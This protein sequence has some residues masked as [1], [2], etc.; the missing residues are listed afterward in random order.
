MF[1]NHNQF[2]N[3]RRIGLVGVFILGILSILGSGGGGGGGDQVT[4]IIPPTVTSTIPVNGAMDVSVNIVVT[5]TFSEDMDDSTIDTSSFTL[6]SNPVTQGT[7]NYDPS[8]RTV[9]FTP[10]AYLDV[11]TLYTAVIS[12]DVA[13]LAGNQMVDNHTWNFTAEPA[14]TFCASTSDELRTALITAA[15]NGKDDLIHV[16]QGIYLGN[17]VYNSTEAFSLTVYGG[18]SAGCVSREIDPA[19]TILDALGDGLVLGLNTDKV[20]DFVVDGLTMRNASTIVAGAGVSVYTGGDLTLSN[21]LISS[22]NNNTSTSG[23]GGGVHVS[24]RSVTFSDNIISDNTAKN[25]GGGAWISANIVALT[26]NTISNNTSRWS[27][28]VAVSNA[29]MVTL[30]NNTVSGNS[31]VQFG[32]AVDIVA[33]TVTLTDN[34]IRNNTGDPGGLK[35]GNPASGGSDV[36]LTNNNF[37]GNTSLG[38]GGG[39]EINAVTATLMNNAISGNTASRGAGGGFLRASTA[40]LTNNVIS[41]NISTSTSAGG[42]FVS[43]MPS[44]GTLKLTNNTITSNVAATLGGGVQ[45]DL[46][47]D[48]VIADM[49]NNIVWG[50]SAPQGADLF[51]DNDANGNFVPSLANLFNNDFDQSSGGIFIT[52]PFTIDPSN[53][54]NLDPFYIDAINDDYKLQAI[55]PVINMGDNN[56]PA[57]PAT[58]KDGKARILNGVVDMGAFEFSGSN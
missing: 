54:D 51:V 45:L 22:N 30:T 14:S 2:I 50:N 19:N 15:S 13:D 25:G 43:I 27:A 53:L 5:A 42:I 11:S 48:S 26:N 9:T 56:A 33:N 32:G 1:T 36:T 31:A 57:I 3:H 29:S 7:V 16:I 39:F 52:L 46:L 24:A 17:F 37:T 44:G 28:G 34:N 58:D 40:T 8:T 38:S 55:S 35:V 41:N 49:Y 10:D 23:S 18:Y 4:D 12:N 21:N 20:A 47:S 6:S